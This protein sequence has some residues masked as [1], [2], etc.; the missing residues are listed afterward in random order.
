MGD[1]VSKEAAS[2]ED[3]RILT[4]KEERIL[5]KAHDLQERK[6]EDCR[7]L[8]EKWIQ[9]ELEQAKKDRNRGTRE[10]SDS[11]SSREDPSKGK[12]KERP[13]INMIR[14]TPSKEVVLTPAPGWQEAV[15]RPEMRGEDDTTEGGIREVEVRF[16][17]GESL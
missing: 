1:K 5:K 4:A 15:G 14:A 2:E 6:R 3:D 7:R 10:R 16:V 9:Q 12:D 17:P 13:R 11:E 8:T